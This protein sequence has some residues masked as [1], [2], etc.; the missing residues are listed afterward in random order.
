MREGIDDTIG[1]LVL[2]AD[3]GLEVVKEDEEEEDGEGKDEV[4]RG[5]AEVELK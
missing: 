2:D 5:E 3:E 1:G 4:W